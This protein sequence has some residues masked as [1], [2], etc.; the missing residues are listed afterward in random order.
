MIEIKNIEDAKATGCYDVFYR[1]IHEGAQPAYS[2]PQPK[3]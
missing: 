1:A 3:A 2:V